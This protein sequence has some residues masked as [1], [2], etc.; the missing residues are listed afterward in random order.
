ML[1]IE[2]LL[3]LRKASAQTALRCKPYLLLTS[4]MAVSMVATDLAINKYVAQKRN[5][6]F[7]NNMV[8]LGLSIRD[9]LLTDNYTNLDDALLGFL[10]IKKSVH[11]LTIFNPSKQIVSAAQQSQEKNS[12]TIVYDDIPQTCELSSEK[13]KPISNRWEFRAITP[14]ENNGVSIGTLIGVAKTDND[15]L[16]TIRSIEA[17]LM[18]SLSVVFVPAFVLLRSSGKRE[19]RME[20][21]KTERIAALI[22]KLEDAEQRTRS[23]FEGTNDGW[24]QWQIHN[25]QATLSDKLIKLLEI[26]NWNEP[27][28]VTE[29]NWWTKYLL[30]KDQNNF[31]QFLQQL[32]EHDAPTPNKNNK[33]IELQARSQRSNSEIQLRIT[34]V[35]T[36]FDANKPSVIALVANNITKEK[37]Q[38]EKIHRLAF[39]DSLTK[40]HNRSSL[41]LEIESKYL[42]NNDQQQLVLFALDL[43]KFKFINDSYGHSVGD[44][45]LIQVAD[46]LRA[47]L[48]RDVFIAR[49]GGDEFVI[50]MSIKAEGKE[51]IKSRAESVAIRLLKT[52]SQPYLLEGCVANNTCSIGISIGH[53]SGE[54]K[55][56]LMDK[57]DLAL[58]QA[59]TNGRNRF[60]FY[61][62]GMA[63][64]IKKRATTA[65]LLQKQLQNSLMSIKLEPIISLSD[66][67][68][69]GENELIR[70]YEALFRC[71]VIGKP[72]PYLIQCAEEA[73][74]IRMI[75]KAVLEKVSEAIQTNTI[76]TPA[77]VSINISPL[78]FLEVNFPENFMEALKQFKISPEQI[79]I[80]ITESTLLQDVATTRKNMNELNAA[81]IEFYLDDFGTGYSSI[82]LLRGLPFHCLKIDRSY[83]SNLHRKSGLRLVKAI[84]DLAKAF[85]LT[86]IG[87]GVE[88]PAQLDA[89]RSMGCD[90]A[91]GFL[92]KD[93]AKMINPHS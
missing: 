39:F 68:I 69:S 23:A 26:D 92:F 13:S 48:D 87:E 56:S 30:P 59:K 88:T 85:N 53:T 72:V 50:L 80:E 28:K 15:S 86:V 63:Q 21:E 57:A 19:V 82:E 40:L 76:D 35:I 37:E 5:S 78:E 20:K 45:L 34:P 27:T 93:Q 29:G 9:D 55:T 16:G 25:N 8:Q 70:G 44:Q 43:D 36:E 60:F 14:L 62:E 73:G 18:F 91:Q 22:N 67:K 17:A 1:F 65:N 46:R 71:P 75:T 83:I 77:Y 31:Q 84:I 6:E 12:P 4:C 66:T 89:I 52:L 3:N 24:W 58:Y 32:I 61:Q 74:I 11:C 90:C 79:K 81:G 2:A 54:S 49:P 33:V 42:N 7:K 47:E 10:R 41:E 51:S 38:R 64:S